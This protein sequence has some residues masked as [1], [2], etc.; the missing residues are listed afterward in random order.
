MVMT[1]EISNPK[2]AAERGEKIYNEKYKSAF[3]AEHYGKFV[4]ID[5]MTEKAHVGDSPEDAIELARKEN[6]K[7]IFHLVK[8]GSAG[9][10]RVSYTNPNANL[11]WLFQ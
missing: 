11:D 3:E 7:G 1:V 10:F 4:A 5:V 6:P 2:I 9:A 8:V